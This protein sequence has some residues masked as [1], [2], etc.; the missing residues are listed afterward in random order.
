MEARPINGPEAALF[1]AY[2]YVH[3]VLKIEHH[4]VVEHY[5]GTNYNT[6]HRIHKKAAGKATTNEF[7][8]RIFIDII[9]KEYQQSLTSGNLNPTELL[10][11]MKDILL[12]NMGFPFDNERL[13]II[14]SKDDT[15]FLE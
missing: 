7:Y 5:Q 2:D 1:F 8:L 9:N 14:Y 6:L 11:V 4:D 13:K 15:S 10:R 3:K 12:L